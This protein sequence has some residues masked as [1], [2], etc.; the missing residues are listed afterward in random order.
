MRLLTSIKNRWDSS[1][2]DRAPPPLPLNPTHSPTT[3]ANTSAGIAAAARQFVERARESQPLSS[4][5]SNNTPQ[6]SPERSLIKGAHHKRMQSLQTGNVKDLRNYLDNRSPERSPERPVS[7][8][9][10][11]SISRQESKED[12]FERST[13]PTPAPRDI[14]K[15]TP[16]LRPVSRP[17][18]RPLLGENTPPSATML[19]LQTMQVPEPP[20]SDITNGPST[21]TLPRASSNYD[22]S[23]QL[24]NLTTIATNLQKE[25]TA[26]SR[27]SKDNAADLCGLKTSTKERDEVI[28]R[29]LRELKAGVD[30]SFLGPPPAIGDMPRSASSNSFLENKA[31][32][33]PPSATKAYTI[34]RA[35]SAHS[36]FLEDRVGSP[37]PFSIEGTASMAMLEKIIRDMVTKDG[38]DHLQRLLTE[39][40]EKSQ[41]ENTEAAKKVEEL[42]E[43]IKEKSGSQAMVRISKDGPPKLDL[44][45][46]S[47]NQ[48]TRDAGGKEAR[49]IGTDA[50]ILKMLDHI[51]NAMTH[52]GGTTSEV[53]TIVRD[54]RGEI[55]GMGRDLGQK[56]ENVSQSQLTNVLDRSIDEGQGKL[57]A[58]EV[59]SIIDESMAE[60]KAHISNLMQ[61]RAE[62]DDNTFKQL[63]ST[64]S[65]PDGDEIHA[66]IKHALSEH[67]DSIV[68][69][70]PESENVNVDRDAILEVVKEG[71]EGFEPDISIQQFGLEREEILEVLKQG[72]EDY[73]NSRP[74]VGSVDKGDVFEAVQEALKDFRTPLP[75][76]QIQE[77]KEELL[78][79]IRQALEEFTPPPAAATDVMATR[80]A[81][82]EAV[83]EGLANHGPAAPREME[84]S[85][86]DLFDAVK[87]SLDGSSIPFGGLGEEVLRQLQELVD[88]MRVEFQQYIA[89]NGRDTEQ[90]LD[91]VKDGLETL[92]GEVESYVDRAQDVTGKDEIVDAMK[93]GLEQLRTDVQGFVAEG[94]TNDNSK[95]DML[96]YLRHEF[97]HLHEVIGD[98]DM[99]RDGGEELNPHHA[100]KVI[101]S[102]K[103]GMDELK[104]HV[105]NG[106]SRGIDD[107]EGGH[108]EEMLEAMKEEFNQL[109]TE[110]LNANANDKSELIE[111]IQDS[112]GALHAKFNSSELSGGATEDIINEMHAEFAQ[113]KESLHSIIGDAD[114]D[115][116][117]S[118]V[119]QSI[120]D[121]RIQ[122]SADQSDAAA[123]ALGAIKEELEGFKES[124]GSSVVVGGGAG[125]VSDETLASIRSSLD[126]IKETVA[127]SGNLGMTDELLEAI[128]GE[129]DKVR[130]TIATSVVHGG[131]QEEVLDAVRLGLDDLRSHIDKKSEDPDQRATQHTELVD[132]INEGLESLHTDVIKT[133]DKPLDMTVN[134]EILDTLKEGLAGLRADIDKLKSA[135]GT[136][137]IPKGGEIVLA[138][139]AEVG[140]AR[141]ISA[142]AGVAAGVA[143]AAASGMNQADVEKIEISIA[144]LQIKIDAMSASLQ[145]LPAMKPSGDSAVKDDI[146]ALEVILREI[147]D[148]VATVA[149]RGPG[150][151]SATKE[152][153]DAIETLLRNTKSQL[154]EMAVPD[155]ANVVTKDH[156][157]AVEAVVRIT[158]EGIDALVEKFEN[159][160]A[161]K[162]DLAV[163]E[164]LAQDLKIAM[165]ELKERVPLPDPD[166]EKPELM[167]KADLD[168]LGVMCTDIKMKVTEMVLPDPDEL[169]SKS[170][171]EQLHGLITDF[172]ESHD[173][174]KE[175]YE[176]DIAV[177]AKAFDDRKQEFEETVQHISEFKDSLAEIKEELLAKLGDGETSMDTLGETLKSLEE[178]TS[179]EPV[180]AEIQS[181][182]DKVTQEFERA[183]GSIE[184]IT[185]NHQEA[186]ES[187]LERQA[188]HK[189]AL[190]TEIGEKLETY[191]DGLMSKY[192]DAQHAAEEKAKGMEEKAAQQDEMLSSMKTMTDDLRLSIDTL[193]ATLTSFLET[194]DKL[195]E[196]SKTVYNRVDDTFNKLDETQEGLKFEH[197]VTRDEV[198]KVLAAIGAL[199]SDFTEHNPRFM[200]TLKEVHA[201]L[202]QHYE[203]SQ[204]ASDTAAEHKRMV[205]ELQ[206]QVRGIGTQNEELK[207][208][209][210]SL[211]QLM[212]A[213]SADFVPVPI[214][215]RYDDTVMHEKLDKLM[216]HA[217]D[218]TK[219]SVQLERLDQIHEKVMATAAEVSAF[220]ATQAKQITEEHESKEREAEELALLL[221]RRHVKKDEIEDDITVLNGE[222]ESLGTAVEALK[223]EKDALTAQ[224]SRLAADVSALETAMHIRREEL[225]EMDRKAEAIERR[226][227]EGVMNQSR[228]LLL[229]KGA[230]APPKKKPQG[231]DLRIP[232]N[233]SAISAQ[234]VTSS[235]PAMKANHSLAM[236]SRPGLPRNGALSNTAERRIMSLNQINN[237]VAYG[238]STL[239][240]T[241]SLASQG[242][243]RSHSVKTQYPRKP[244]WAN[245]RDLAAPVE[246]KENDILSEESEDELQRPGSPSVYGSDAATERRTSLLSGRDSYS[247]YPEG[248]VTDGITPGIDESRMSYGTSDLSYGTGSYMT[249]SE[250]D[251]RT[252]LGSSAGGVL[253]SAQEVID[254]EPSEEEFHEMSDGEAEGGAGAEQ[255]QI[256]AA[257]VLDDKKRL[258]Y[259]VASDSG[260]GTD[261]PT[262]ALSSVNGDE[263]FRR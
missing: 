178:K 219:G 99:A 113:L 67:S 155:P 226:M 88:G 260:L 238:G 232:S 228:M 262:A 64:R 15:D 187:S 192:D 200:V 210:S 164:V 21:P 245:K 253:G 134:Y 100:A 161:S 243:K 2:P 19:A 85:R 9:G 40:L 256:E 160:A 75:N 108:S 29:T 225:H 135:D 221:E 55:L 45:F 193:G 217:E 209:V 255:L 12:I 215:E 208:N 93:G 147:Q 26:L 107:E 237:N 234:T 158:N 17:G 250:I 157:D 218:A 78:A 203:H 183:H 224:K 94:P 123:E 212:P 214:P 173:K 20:L 57:E 182:L 83:K 51:K 239:S 130:G 103:E 120:D 259:A 196:E 197:S 58:E 91:A 116:I 204:K 3:K 249:G 32:N 258:Y 195:A 50:E 80:F 154:E 74:D 179:H 263:Y 7:V 98:R 235:V 137:I 163:V 8:S 133:L 184:A 76:D 231:R 36:M 73:T 177:T 54:L 89:A 47:P 70:E 240:S 6:G 69:R 96:E 68:K 105:S 223:A 198:S 246:N 175:S 42:S 129:F 43:F 222:K 185:V 227:L 143:A 59:Q 189:E 220:V 172:R 23:S 230:K 22:L 151:G 13:T 165:D 52:T 86:E 201:L 122:L 35:A 39:L 181:L 261:M 149:D 252:S 33:S 10:F 25:M 191:F 1:D 152:D 242:L 162:D 109:K 167:T 66:V 77:M 194:V 138:D 110:V 115:A 248:S 56:L 28:R 180:T 125:A 46:D 65:G 48:K 4:Y 34:P 53:K 206:E 121:L 148:S 139:G 233:A 84:I 62:E 145:D 82:M 211:P 166:E 81:V 169:P 144:Q 90:V 168:I 142:E 92:R 97:E 207:S 202:G 153:T 236:K 199:Q 114:R 112:I 18:P 140:Q 37:L 14:T 16:S 24:L 72:F 229:A 87:A 244:S 251:R 171:V 174:L 31:Y 257:P 205:E 247:T 119:K 254:E 102:L 101:L 5:T 131:S 132:A 79:N 128:Q 176:T 141:D 63:A 106:R 188:E 170:D 127:N 60:L 104:S 95:A 49:M 216:G 126:E 44:N 136:A 111:T 241:S 11:S 124:M 146:V 30:T 71:L 117:V 61:Q 190:A 186:A 156:L 159:S 150:E 118:G 38:Q 27:R 213:P 41:K